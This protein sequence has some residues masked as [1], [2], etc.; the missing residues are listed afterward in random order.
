MS[1]KGLLMSSAAAPFLRKAKWSKLDP[2][3]RWRTARDVARRVEAPA[4]YFPH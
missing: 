2:I 3:E 4:G 1:E